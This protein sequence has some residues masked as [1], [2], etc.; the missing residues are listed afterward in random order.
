MLTVLIIGIIVAP[1]IMP[2]KDSEY[3]KGE[4]PNPK[5]KTLNPKTQTLN[6]K[7]EIP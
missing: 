3:N 5:R 7:P 6:P 2:I 4:H 1:S